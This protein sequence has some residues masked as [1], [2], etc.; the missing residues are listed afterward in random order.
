MEKYKNIV[1]IEEVRRLAE[2]KEYKKAALI[3]D[4]MN[5][6]KIKAII[7]LTTIADVLIQNHRYE[8]ATEVLN[9]VYN[10]TQS[11]RVVNQL[12]EVSIRS[13]DLPLAKKYYKEYIELAP[14]DPWRFIFKYLMLRLEDRPIEEQITQLE[15]LKNQEYMEEWA[16][17]LA[18][19]Y[20]KAGM[21]KECIEECNNIILWF[22]TGEYVKRAELLK[23]H[24]EGK[25]DLLA[26]L[27]EKQ[28][29]EQKQKE[30]EEANEEK[31][32]IEE[33]KEKKEFQAEEVQ[34]EE[35]DILEEYFQGT[36]I[37]Y[38][39]IF[40]EFLNSI[41]T[42]Q[43]I[44][45]ILEEIDSNK[46]TYLNLIVSSDKSLTD[47]V[48]FTKAL[49]KVLYRLKMIKCEKVGM[50]DAKDF[51]TIDYKRKKKVIKNCSLIIENASLM[52]EQ[53]VDDVEELILDKNQTILVVLLDEEEKINELFEKQPQ[54]FLYFHNRVML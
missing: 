25:V 17:E 47:T 5:I 3:I 29:E 14:R 44:V 35:K 42:K 45:N 37:D 18:G 15:E 40:A 22:A 49:L 32:D 48:S 38:K 1:K 54:L 20:H 11:R 9:K 51:N 31:E 16:Y 28:L 27:K 50:I 7:D 26:I 30:A 8:E 53:A 46:A 43:Q 13:K 19:L 12:L 33:D 52:E 2:N 41:E 36:D 10:R 6:K 24:H 39:G 4:D 21:E 34:E 23:N